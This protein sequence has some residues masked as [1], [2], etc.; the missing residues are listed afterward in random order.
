MEE[1]CN[2]WTEKV[3]ATEEDGDS[4]SDDVDLW[5]DWTVLRELYLVY[6]VH[7]KSVTVLSHLCHR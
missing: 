1:C 6:E 2:R 4:D 5:D 7:I 3:S